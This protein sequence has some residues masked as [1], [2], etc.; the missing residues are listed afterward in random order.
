MKKRN[1]IIAGTM[2]LALSMSMVV[3]AMAEEDPAAPGLDPGG[4]IESLPGGMDAYSARYDL[5]D[6]AMKAYVLE[7][8]ADSMD[9]GDVQI[10]SE[11]IAYMDDDLFQDEVKILGEFIQ[12]NFT[13]ED[14]EMHLC[15]S[16]SVPMLFTVTEAED[17]SIVV[18]EVEEAED[19]EGWSDS[20]TAMCEK[21]GISRDDYD[22]IMNVGQNHDL[23]A[24]AQFLDE[25]P[26][27]TGAEFMGEIKTV[28][29]L[30][31]ISDAYME[32]LF[33]EK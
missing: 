10:V 11:N 23:E 2:V 9:P 19:G 12:Q 17:G 5:I 32:E 13:I 6:E 24:I 31:A 15:G 4:I 22:V 14:D 7:S 1:M 25:H 16:S 26:E 21:A 20:V 30:H 27:I 18:K 3:P 33:G 29:E 8:N 28:E